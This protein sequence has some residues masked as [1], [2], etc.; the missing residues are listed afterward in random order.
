MSMRAARIFT[1]ATSAVIVTATSCLLGMTSTALAQQ[2]ALASTTATA[3]SPTDE[4]QAAVQ[5]RIKQLEAELR[6]LRK[7]AG[8]QKPAESQQAEP[9]VAALTPPAVS[10]LPSAAPGAPPS[11]YAMAPRAPAPMQPFNWTG[12][13]AGLSLGVGFLNADA[14]TNSTSTSISKDLPSPP[15]LTTT[16]TDNAF[17]SGKARFESGALADAYIGYSRQFAPNW[18]GAAQLEA[19]LGRLFARFNENGFSNFTDVRSDVGLTNTQSST[20]TQKDSLNITFMVSALAKLGYLVT[21]RDL[22]YG[23]AGWTYAGF[24]TTLPTVNDPAFGAHGVTVGG[25]WERQILDSWT[26]KL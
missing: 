18:V 4:S 8:I 1:P 3:P 6:V 9:K 25:G 14:S 5:A 26:W 24:N 22:V 12:P 20:F 23:L 10:T 15:G 16:D 19:S 7:K 17:A 11:A 2:V 13:Y 21:P